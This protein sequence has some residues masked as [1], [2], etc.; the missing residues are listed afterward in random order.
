MPADELFTRDEALGGLP[1][2]RAA[3]LLFLIESRSAHFEARA[4]LEADEFATEKAAQE[5]DLAFIEAFALSRQ[6]PLRV[7]IQDLERHAQKWAYL[8]PD[9]ARL[10][11]AIAR[12]LSEKYSFT[13]EAVP[14]IRSALGLDQPAVQRAYQG[15]YHQS[16]DTIFASRVALIERL[17]WISTS[18]A[19]SLDSLPPFWMTFTLVLT[20]S[21]P[22]ATL[23]LPIAT[24]AV[25][26]LAA[27]ALLL[28]FGVINLL[29]MACMAEAFARN[30]SIRYGSAFTGRVV[31]DY[32]GEAGSRLLVLATAVRLFLGLV[33]CYYGLSMTM[34]GLT[35]IRPTV[36]AALLFLLALYFLAG[37]S[38]NFSTSLSA[39]LGA[40]SI[41]LIF[42]IGLAASTHIQ[43][44]NV[45][46]VHVHLTGGKPFE[47]TVL[48]LIL[49]IVIGSYLAHAYLTQCAKVVLPR[50]PG[51]RS[52]IRG[53]AAASVA[54]T[55]LLCGWVLAVNGAVSPVALAA[56][57]NTVLAPLAREIG[58]QV[59]IL[60]FFLIILLLG[61]GFIRQSTVLFNLARE[62][63]PVRVRSTVVLP[64]RRASL[65]LSKNATSANG[66]QFA[67]TYLGISEGQPL[68]RVDVQI[69]KK[70]H[71]TEFK[72]DN[73]WDAAVL[74]ERLP[75][76]RLYGI[77]LVVEL[78]EA[79]SDSAQL[80]V[81]STMTLKY[82]GEWSTA[83]LHVADV[84]T[85]RD[86]LRRLVNWI[87]R[88][89]E[90]SLA[91]IT[92]YSGE[93]ENT[94]RQMIDELI[95]MGFVQ[96]LERMGDPRYRIH[97]AGRHRRQ[98]PFDIWQ[99]L[100]E[101]CERATTGP[102]LTRP[103]VDP[104][105][106]WFRRLALNEA[107][108]FILSMSPV[109]GV[110]ALTE[111]LIFTNTSSF[112]GVLA[113]GG[114]LG[115]SIVSGV[116]P[117]LLLISSRR[118]GDLVPDVVI[119]VLGHVPVVG[120]IYLL[121]VG[122]LFLNAI[123]ILPHPAE[124]AAAFFVGLLVLA[125]T[126]TMI[127]QGA[128][129]RRLVV[130]FKE[131]SQGRENGRAMFSITAIG[132]RAAAEVE[133]HYANCDERRYEATGEVAAFTD[134]QSIT[135]KLPPSEARELKVWAHTVKPD[136]SSAS[137]PANVDL[138][139]GNNIQRFDLK[140]SDGVIVV[141]FNGDACRVQISFAE[142][143]P[144]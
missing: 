141:P 136:G 69:D 16:I 10:R 119:R 44:A 37:K 46:Y 126:V 61:L 97:L 118:K 99:S 72:I 35:A 140:I 4:R 75:E 45:S 74:V 86:P 71:R 21:L 130:E 78:A 58:P 116:L 134:L 23:A 5:L 2:R 82:E 100:E 1:A 112:T 11:A 129:R 34:A 13:S 19:K 24:A 32:V 94:A 54:T 115:N 135:F 30:G 83:G 57:T 90:V 60:G 3:T 28:F 7:T 59:N 127:R 27:I 110:F 49:G 31:S 63:I 73:T 67:L 132:Q 65:L 20:L 101:T 50:D 89:G 47:R 64:R 104:M 40:V 12:L 8:I 114:L 121:F 105:A 38:L 39:L 125:T 15:L 17:R 102:A 84:S 107:T 133:M 96:P 43:W 62:R 88:Q 68:F 139:Y 36:W 123:V 80:R 48:Q 95:E 106:L 25:G 124:R 14:A 98:V 79:S 77:S 131:D 142:A 26:P 109:I 111:W 22:Q 81:S 66:P 85:L 76:L 103:G 108:R 55:V 29:T 113:V 87:T 117:V 42:V 92:A 53:T 41:S 137:M 91:E 138:E 122:I 9:N 128:F 143:M 6:P 33:A 120:F 51:G 70:I 93:S 52:L 56:E 144:A 18:L